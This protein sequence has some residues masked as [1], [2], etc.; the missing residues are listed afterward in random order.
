MFFSQQRIKLI[1]LEMLLSLRN[2]E[3]TLFPLDISDTH[4]K[5]KENQIVN[6]SSDLRALKH[7]SEDKCVTK[8]PLNSDKC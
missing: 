4:D 2:H 5:T 8:C 7:G 1:K 6:S 3:A